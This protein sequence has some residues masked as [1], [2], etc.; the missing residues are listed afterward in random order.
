MNNI[1]DILDAYLRE[2]ENGAGV[3]SVLAR[4]PE[5]ANELRPILKASLQARRMASQP[6]P[7]AD[8]LRR[9]RAKLMQR[10]TELRE[11]K[12]APRRRVISMFQRLALSFALTTLLLASWT[13][14]VSASSSALP[15]ENLYPVKR[16]WESLRL[17]FTFTD[18]R[19]V[20][21]ESEFKG[22]RLEEVNHLIAEGRHEMIQFAGVF[23][24]VN[25]VSYASGV[26]ALISENTLLP[27][28]ILQNG[29]AVVVTGRTNASGFVEVESIVLLPDGS[30]VPVGSPIEVESESDDES[31]S[32]SSASGS[33]SGN[34][35]QGNNSGEENGSESTSFQL[36]GAVDSVSNDTI[37]VNGQTV[38][39]DGARIDG[40]I[41]PGVR[42]EIEGYFAA[43][44]KF[45]AT[46]LKVED[47][48]SGSGD[49]ENNS[50]S[51]SN[52]DSSGSGSGDDDSDDDD[53]RSGPG[54]G[55]D[56]D[57]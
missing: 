27:D 4:H 43:D 32:S 8:T 25:G 6:A 22:E 49:E 33:G 7:S 36:E 5:H 23:M 1:Y 18:A 45:I 53:A 16:S 24:E 19:R 39:L 29:A 10:A 38:Y 15:G 48:N 34:E 30:I 37:V 2:L 26:P 51:S 20:L 21:L 12:A 3:E 50:G 46:K 57:D 11:E 41:E 52:S 35:A 47:L 44:G 14:L 54:G 17:F 13:G 9:G 31:T 56:A 40:K 42:V 55:E 28:R